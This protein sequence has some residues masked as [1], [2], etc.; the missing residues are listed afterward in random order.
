MG[1][2]ILC[3]LGFVIGFLIMCCEG[4]QDGTP[5]ET[6]FYVAKAIGFSMFVLCSLPMWREEDKFWKKGKDE[7]SRNN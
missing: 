7:E 3:V 2:K 6:G 4:K 1:K 5:E